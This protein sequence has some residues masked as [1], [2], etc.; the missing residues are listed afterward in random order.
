MH[1]RRAQPLRRDESACQHGVADRVADG[2]GGQVAV[3]IDHVGVEGRE[4]IC[5]GAR[6]FSAARLPFAIEGLRGGCRGLRIAP[7]GALHRAVECL[8]AVW[9]GRVV[10][11]GFRGSFDDTV[12][13]QAEIIDPPT[14]MGLGW[15]ALPPGWQGAV[16]IDAQCVQQLCEKS[17][18]ID[19]ARLRILLLLYWFS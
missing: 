12:F 7:G 2:V 9:R 13:G 10:P 19:L 8:G 3:G 1:A 5:A 16:R 6:A 11:P 18:K 14:H 15:P 4:F 17:I